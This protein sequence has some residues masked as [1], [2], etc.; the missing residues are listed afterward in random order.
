[1]R[2][3]INWAVF[4]FLFV[5]L[6]GMTRDLVLGNTIQKDVTFAQPVTVNDTVVKAGTYKVTFDDETNQLTI[7][8]DKKVI[9]KA[10]ARIEK[11]E[12]SQNTYVTRSESADAKAPPTLLSV[13]LNNG[14]RAAIVGKS[15][16]S[17][18]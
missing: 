12:G 8:K 6:A 14:T 15:A 5:V 1:M 10:D 7:S 3:I 17:T 16:S 18:Q 9:V 13:A 4:L 2:R 11:V